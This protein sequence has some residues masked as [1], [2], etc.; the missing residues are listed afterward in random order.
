MTISIT[1]ATTTATT[2]KNLRRTETGWN[3]KPIK[4]QQKPI[5]GNNKD[6]GLKGVPPRD[7][8]QFSVNRLEEKT[9]DDEVRRH[10]HKQGIEVRDVWMLRSNIKGT[11]TAKIKVA[12]AHRERAKNV[13]IWPPHCRIRD[14]VFGSDKNDTR[15]DPAVPV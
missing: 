9:T 15:S 5:T 3:T 4:K 8:W 14:W 10:L 7:H 12:R 2:T 6:C 1:T 11:K 13:A